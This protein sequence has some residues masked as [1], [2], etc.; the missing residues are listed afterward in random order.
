MHDYGVCDGAMDII[1]DE[2]ELEDSTDEQDAH[3]NGSARTRS[4]DLTAT[5][6]QQIYEALLQR[7][8]CGELRRNATK[9]VAELFNVNR[10]AVW[11]IWR[12]VK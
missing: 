4:K 5:Q 6:R 11:R 7:S 3:E 9:T 12:R 1:F 8:N 10:H 2:E